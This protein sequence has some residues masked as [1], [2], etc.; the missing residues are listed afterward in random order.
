MQIFN[1]KSV[2]KIT[3]SRPTQK[4]ISKSMLQN[5]FICDKIL[6]IVFKNK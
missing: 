5:S 2:H 1:G 4:Q 6:N 3:V